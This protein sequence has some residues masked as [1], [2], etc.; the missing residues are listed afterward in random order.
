MGWN[1]IGEKLFY[2]QHPPGGRIKRYIK[3]KPAERA[4]YLGLFVLFI[5]N[6]H[7][8]RNGVIILITL[9]FIEGK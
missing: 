5:F 9:F 4:F 8:V 6:D 2:F 3:S 7:W 1:K